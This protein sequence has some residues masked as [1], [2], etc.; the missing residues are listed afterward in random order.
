MSNKSRL[1]EV[2][3]YVNKIHLD[4]AY[5]TPIEKQKLISLKKELNAQKSINRGEWF[6]EYKGIEWALTTF[7]DGRTPWY[8]IEDSINGKLD[9]PTTNIIDAFT[10]IKGNIDYDKENEIQK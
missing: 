3:E 1:I 10:A 2:F 6:G 9:D 7:M 8:Y 4:E 5:M